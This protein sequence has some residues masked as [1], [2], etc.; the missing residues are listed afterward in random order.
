MKDAFVV[1]LLFGCSG[2]PINPN[3]RSIIKW[4]INQECCSIQILQ[5][6]RLF[7]FNK[8]LIC[9]RYTILIIS[10]VSKSLTSRENI[11]LN[12]NDSTQ[13]VNPLFYSALVF[14]DFLGSISGYVYGDMLSFS[15]LQPFQKGEQ[16]VIRN[17]NYVIQFQSFPTRF[18][19]LW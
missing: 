2:L 4:I 9:L 18:N 3:K 5:N 7:V 17:P 11:S 12:H 8:L 15:S 1:W 13:A 16:K 6:H 19:F 10:S 14:L